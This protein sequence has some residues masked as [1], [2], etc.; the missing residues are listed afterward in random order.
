MAYPWTEIEKIVIW[1]PQI[2]KLTIWRRR[3]TKVIGVQRRERVTPV[4][5]GKLGQAL[6]RSSLAVTAPGVPLNVAATGVTAAT[7]A[8]DYKR[9]TQAVGHFAPNVEVV[10]ST[11]GRI[12]Y[13]P[14]R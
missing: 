7:W 2:E 3:K 5:G 12:L 6:A 11:T 10:D 8:L 4:R 9:L 1:E 14:D 13:P